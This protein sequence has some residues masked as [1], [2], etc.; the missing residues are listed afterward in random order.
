MITKRQLTKLRA[1]ANRDE[2]AELIETCDRL[3]TVIFAVR[4]WKR[5]PAGREAVAAET[6]LERA[7]RQIIVHDEPP[8]AA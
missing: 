1:D 3:W 5:A 2:V 7:L 6:N 8:E 4:A